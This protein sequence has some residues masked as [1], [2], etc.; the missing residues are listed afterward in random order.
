M[1]ISNRIT[2]LFA[3]ILVLVV[4]SLACALQPPLRMYVVSSGVGYR[5]NPMGGGE[6]AF[7]RGLDMVGPPGAEILAAGPGTVVEHWPAPGSFGKGGVIFRGHPVFGGMIV[8]DHGNGVWTIY[9]HMRRTRV[10]TGQHVEAGQVIGWQ[11][12]TG[13]A[14]GE[15][16]H[17]EVIVDPRLMFDAPMLNTRGGK[18]VSR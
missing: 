8:I 17:F 10:H 14:T 12:A 11:G 15:H 3:A 18:A 6:E 5:V 2:L 7:H 4:P 1:T 16:L 9:G 13:D